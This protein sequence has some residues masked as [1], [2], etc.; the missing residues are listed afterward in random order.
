MVSFH[1]ETGNIGE[2]VGQRRH[3]K[4]TFGLSELHRLDVHTGK[5]MQCRIGVKP[6]L[7]KDP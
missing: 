3:E 1:G 6:W 2:R 4:I 7:C 5:A